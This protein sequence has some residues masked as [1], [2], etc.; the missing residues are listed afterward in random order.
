MKGTNSVLYELGVYINHKWTKVNQYNVKYN[1]I[2][3]FFEMKGANF[4]VWKLNI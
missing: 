2:L 1:Y 4:L 3:F